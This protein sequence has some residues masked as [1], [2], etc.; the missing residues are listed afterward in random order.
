MSRRC[1]AVRSARA[2]WVALTALLLFASLPACAG[3]IEL[4]TWYQFSHTAA[5]LPAV[6]C[7]PADPNGQFCIPS[8]GTP[9]EFLDAPAWTFTV[10]LVG[11]RLFVTDSFLNGD[12][13]EVFNFG[14]SLGLT[15]QPGAAVDCGDD[16]VPCIANPDVS[17]GVFNLAPGN[18]SITIT[19]V[20]APLGGGTGFLQVQAV[21]EPQTWAMAMAGFAAAAALRHRRRFA[22]RQ[23]LLPGGT[24]LVVVLAALAW[25]DP[26]GQLTGPGAR[27]AGPTS[28]QPLA[29]TADGSFLASVNPD[30]NSV[31]FFDVRN[32]VN[33]RLAEVPVQAEPNGV[34]MLP[35]G[36]KAYI[37]NTVTG[38]V[39]VVQLI[40]QNGII[41]R[42]YRHIAV[43]TE[44]YGVALTPNGSKLYVTNARSN[45][46]TVIDTATDR[47]LS[48]IQNVG[49]EPRGIAITNDGD[50]NDD[51]ETVLVTQ[52]L[53]L[54]IA[55]RPDG[56]DDAKAAHVTVISSQSDAVT[57]EITINPVADTGF[58]ATGDALARIPPADP[59]VEANF[60]FVTGAYP[61]QLNNVAIKGGFAYLPN[62]GVSANGPVRFDVNTQSLLAVARLSTKEDAGQTINMHRA[63]ADQTNPSRLF[64]TQ[65]WAIAFEHGSTDGYVIS[66]AS[67]VVVKVVL[68]QAT[69]KPT[70]Q[71]DPLDPT[72]VHQIKV[73]KHPRGLVV[74]ASDSR[75][76]V[77]NLVSKDITVLN[78]VGP[79]R[80]V[81]TMRSAA[82]PA[83]GSQAEKVLIGKEL[84]HT[85]VG[86]FDAPAPG[87]PVITGRMSRA[88][89][90]SCGSCHPFGLTDNAVWIFPPGPRRT[91]PQHT[92]FDL[93]DPTRST[94]RALNW[95]AERDVNADFELNIR[96]VSGGQGLIVLAD[97]ITQD[98]NVANFAPL[99]SRG[100]NQLKVRGV[101]SWDAIEEYV[102]FGI[103]PPISPLAQTDPDVVAGRALFE[104]ANCQSCH[105][106]AQW[107]SA[108]VRFPEP[109]L[110][111]QVVAGQLI[112]ELR[113][114]GTFDP[115]AQNEV[116]QNAAPP[117]GAAGFSPASLLSV[118]A[119][120][121]TFL[122]NG[123][124][125]SL[126]GVL[127]NVQHRSFGTGGVDTLTNAADRAK[128]VKFMQSIDANTQPF[129]LP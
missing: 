30:N 25:N 56:Q 123:A 59:A 28:S 99:P 107:T 100:R 119:F 89:W 45:S 58:K 20:E 27:F 16:P 127:N 35:D 103:R 5:G 128:V 94:Q 15:S 66:T 108:R 102:K 36:S 14:A 8:S 32:D 85:S 95:S 122:H 114:V 24:L 12:R 96:A 83:P 76:Y 50:E 71:N 65:P 125:T 52:F 75:A 43:G 88:G 21:P 69:G 9:T 129:P 67:N 42:P 31:T 60:R 22:L 17:S 41:F 54:P 26:T 111:D 124:E 105:G 86:E 18:Y 93:T 6:G 63:V 106:G 78:L 49:P 110:A 23:A 84:Y 2:R 47:V 82:L 91:I 39:S 64:L 118:F 109:P 40:L 38:S 10:P 126:D 112:N 79:E 72:K 77:M 37:A 3:P 62:T 61:N 117:L 53:S 92:D 104:A 113:Q 34:A 90:G 55:G 29:L 57:G 98:P 116:R 68:D 120:P 1:S 4:G 73:G 80:A 44:P 74:N 33:R 115:N 97:G 121:Q 87:Q 70:V 81:A 19:P 51:D 13:Y 46:V 48:T 11:G 7:D 101:N